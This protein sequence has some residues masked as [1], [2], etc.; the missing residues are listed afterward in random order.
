MDTLSIHGVSKITL[1][2]TEALNIHD[3]HVRKL[4]VK[5]RNGQELEITLFTQDAAALEIEA[6][7]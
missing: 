2:K 4:I 7:K 3:T 6:N 5:S 1:T